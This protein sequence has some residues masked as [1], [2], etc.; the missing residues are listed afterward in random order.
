MSSRATRA[1]PPPASAG[2]RRAGCARRRAPTSPVQGECHQRVHA[3]LPTRHARALQKSCRAGARF[4]RQR[5]ARRR[6]RFRR[7]SPARS[8]AS[9]DAPCARTSKELRAGRSL[10]SPA[11]RAPTSPV[12]GEC[13]QRVHAR[14]PTRYARALQSCRAGR[15]LRSPARPAAPARE[16]HD[17]GPAGSS[18]MLTCAATTASRRRSNPGLHLATDLAAARRGGTTSRPPRSR[19]RRW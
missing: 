6:A 14:L 12:Q 15:S 7:V 4:A 9:S 16:C 1:A 2:R 18:I 5:G 13:H 11:R 10:R 8:R 19:G 3:R 17:D